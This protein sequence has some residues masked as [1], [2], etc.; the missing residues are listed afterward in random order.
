NAL[1]HT[2]FF[3]T[4]SPKTTAQALK[5]DDSAKTTSG[6]SINDVQQG[7]FCLTIR[8]ACGQPPEEEI[9]Q[10]TTLS[11][12]DDKHSFITRIS[13]FT[14]LIRVTA[15]CLR[16]ASKTRRAKLRIA[17]ESSTAALTITELRHAAMT[18]AK[19]TL[20]NTSNLSSRH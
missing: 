7:S 19:L 9:Y 20:Q 17:Y 11:T 6:L 10:V 16:F 12:T 2:I 4:P 1:P 15:Y 14:R 13:T 18:L 5:F 3:I 8:R